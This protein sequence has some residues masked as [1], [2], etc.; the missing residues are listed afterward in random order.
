MDISKLTDFV[1]PRFS[2][3]ILPWILKNPRYLKNAPLLI[4]AFWEC[5][6]TR[7]ELLLKENLLVPPVVILSITNDCNLHCQGC[8]VEK[9]SGK[10]MTLSDWNNVI[11][12]AKDLGVFAFLIAGGE[13][14]LL[15][16]PLD[17]TFS[18]KDRVFAIFSNGTQINEE[19]LKQLKSSSN[20]AVIL[21]IE[22]D[23]ELTD[24]R[25][26]K[27]VH[28]RAME[29]LKKLSDLGVMN[30]V[31]VTITRD[32]YIY[33]MKDENIDNLAEIGAKLC[34]FIE[35]IGAEEDGKTLSCEQRKSFREK[36]LQYKDTKP[37]FIIHSPG[38][39]EPFGGCVSAG[40]GFIHINAF[41]DLTPC[42][43]TTA[44]TNNLKSTTLK[45]GL[46]SNLFKEIRESKLLEDGD[47]PCSL[48]SHK[49]ELRQIVL[50][51]LQ[52]KTQIAETKDH[53]VTQ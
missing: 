11:N 10:Q 51:C 48:I 52:T 34:F 30:G 25:R 20:T 28:R 36:I 5:E 18:H 24:Q 42:P 12:Q 16:N 43:V 41:G 37:V 53:A 4:K 27:G 38:D 23:E 33:W 45:E 15:E 40:R 1:S 21:S 14:F 47:G 2:R 39:E 13:P 22:G 8:F 9:L 50:R 44:S 17:L 3:A 32:N 26:G 29:T 35:Y 31:S 46:K 7:K 19:R 49:D 6:S